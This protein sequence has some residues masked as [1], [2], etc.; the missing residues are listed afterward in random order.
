M[1]T[2]ECMGEC[3]YLRDPTSPVK[4]LLSIDAAVSTFVVRI[5]VIIPCVKITC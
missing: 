2:F 1:V 3:R 4:V 5:F